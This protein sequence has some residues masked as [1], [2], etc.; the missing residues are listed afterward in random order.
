MF[1]IL[2]YDIAAERVAKASKIA[3]KYLTLRHRS[4]YDGFITEK[5][6]SR[7]KAELGNL[8]N[9]EYDSVIIY[10]TTDNG[11]PAVDAVGVIKGTRF[12]GLI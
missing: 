11:V 5:Q 10:R 4:V 7:L 6:L 8:L 1:V 12:D 2:T 9:F 3:K